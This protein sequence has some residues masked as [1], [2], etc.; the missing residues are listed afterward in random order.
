MFRLEMS[1]PFRS[2]WNGG[3]GGPNDG[4]H[5]PPLW[6]IQYGMDLGVAAGTELYA[7]FDGTIT[8]FNP[9]TPSGNPKVYGHQLFVRYD[10]DRMGGFYTHFNDSGPDIRPGQ[11]IVRGQRLGKIMR[12]HLH[13]ALV[14]IIG[15]A[16]GGRYV[17]IDLYRHFLGLA[18]LRDT[19]I[20]VTFNEDGTPPDVAYR[21]PESLL[22]SL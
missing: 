4:G 7:A 13:L 10:N 6:Y 21:V 14:E 17:G 9:D 3:I 11:P 20:A 16:P 5:K 19:S 12:D 18:D 22:I 2:G 1:S 8:R 15:G